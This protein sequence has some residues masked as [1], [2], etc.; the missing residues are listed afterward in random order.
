MGIR[1]RWRHLKAAAKGLF[2]KPG[3]TGTPPSAR[4]MWHDPAAHAKDFAERY[5]DPLNYQVENRMME[6]GIHT[7][8]IGARKYGYPHRAFWPEETTGGGNVPGRRLTVDSGVF[9]TELMANRP[10]AG[11]LWARS[12]L[13]DRIDAIIAHEDAESLT[14]DHDLAEAMAPDTALP[15]TEGAR[16]I[17]RAI[18]RNPRVR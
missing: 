12:R 6:L 13:R 11:P 2:R 3:M 14:G 17:L 16:H 15:I 18:R 9:N 5:A 10:D 1:D 4:P 8:R 7:D